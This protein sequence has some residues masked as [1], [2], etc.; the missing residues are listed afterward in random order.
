MERGPASPFI[1]KIFSPLSTMS[2]SY[3]IGEIGQN[4]NG[5]VDIAK[6]LI[7]IASMP[8]IDNT[9]REYPAMDAIKLTKR[10]LRE[11][12]TASEMAKPYVS[13]HA[14]GPTYGE[15]RA[16]LELDDQQHA[17]LYAYAKQ[18]GLDVIETICSR[19]A[20]SLLEH[21]TPDQLKVASRDL[22]NLPLLDALAATCIPL[23]L[24]CG[25]ADERDLEEALAVISAHH[26]RITI[27]HCLSQYPA[28]FP[29]IN[30]HTITYL[31]AKYPQY[32]I[33][34]SDHTIGIMTPIAAV[35][36]GAVVIEKHITLNRGM[37][38]SDHSG[39]LAPDGIF[40]MMRDIRH[41]EEALG[42]PRL[43]AHPAAEAARA[44][45]ERSIAA[46]HDLKPGQVIQLTDIHLLSPGT[47]LR[48][49]ERN[50][51][52]GRTVTRYIKKD[53]LILGE[54]LEGVS[55]KQ[56]HVVARTIS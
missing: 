7:D 28:E 50:H 6:R 25:M 16:A 33:G 32:T 1:W 22:T 52:I 31:R 19:G 51:I 26:Q 42:T 44:K 21:F 13:P 27:L 39:S 45:L 18:R 5:S 40:R 12:L 46:K 36:L 34:Y 3:I 8:V 49:T 4:H 30:L 24:S 2:T 56:S 37:K 47:G 29:N 20:L 35:A 9:G 14:F 43:A 55:S 11:E 53:E 54:Y 38:G 10:D 15:H 48:W 17:E 41:L 23:I